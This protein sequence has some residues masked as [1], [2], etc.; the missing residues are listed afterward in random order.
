MQL[1]RNSNRLR[2]ASA[3]FQERCARGRA[4]RLDGHDRGGNR[5][6]CLRAGVGRLQPSFFGNKQ[7]GA[8]ISPAPLYRHDV[9]RNASQTGKAL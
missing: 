4:D 3:T 5:G 1:F 7:L 2:L 8:G 9:S 6:G